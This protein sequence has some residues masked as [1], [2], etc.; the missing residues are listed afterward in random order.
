M[1][2]LLL[3]LPEGEGLASMFDVG[4]ASAY[5]TILIFVLS[6]PLMWKIVFGPIIK[7]L[8][9][10]EHAARD[11]ASV[12]EAARQV[13]EALKA[14]IECDL[15]EAR[16]EARERIQEA[17][18]RATAKEQEIVSA[19]KDEAEKERAR[20]RQEIERAK[21]SAIEEL[22]QTAIELGVGI[23]EKAIGREFAADDQKRLVSELQ[24]E[25]SAD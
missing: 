19:A 2:N 10:R 17:E 16:R 22:R 21:A 25:V 11:A 20:S 4:Q 6:L 1:N 18:A 9:S 14:S 24:S 8:D 23:A 3:I 13:S 5:W 15:A 12:A 7:A